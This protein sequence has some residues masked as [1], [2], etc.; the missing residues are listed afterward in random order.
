PGDPRVDYP[1]AALECVTCGSFGTLNYQLSIRMR[2][3]VT[4]PERAPNAA[5]FLPAAI[6]PTAVPIPAVAAIINASFSQDRRLPPPHNTSPAF[7]R[8]SRD[9]KSTRL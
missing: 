5:P 3:R 4:P 8:T 6:A 1:G 7:I 2:N 9:R